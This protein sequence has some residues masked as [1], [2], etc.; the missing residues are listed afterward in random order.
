MSKVIKLKRGL[1]IR[2]VGE[3]DKT[4]AE[5]PVASTYAVLPDSFPC[6]TPKLL[7]AE[8]DRVKA[9]T[10]LFFDK[11]RPQ[12]LFTAP[13]SGTVSAIRRGE[14]RKILSVV[15]D[16]DPVIEYE[17]FQTPALPNK[18][19][20]EQVTELL[21]QSGLWPMLIQRPYGIIANPCDAPK[22]IFISGFDSADRKSV[23]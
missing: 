16:A 17:K 12:I 18:L 11:A 5:M 19:S 10:P 6:I 7:V 14:K 20:K 9:G 15:I 13:V 2:L 22:N 8:G 23:V 3:A 1:D 4:V 21:L